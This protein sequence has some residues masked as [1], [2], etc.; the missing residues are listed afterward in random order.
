MI[1]KI[2]KGVKDYIVLPLFVKNTPKTQQTTKEN[3]K[4]RTLELSSAADVADHI[5]TLVGTPGVT[6][7]TRYF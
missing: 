7:R 5:V 1:L 2:Q 3:K 6:L 4:I